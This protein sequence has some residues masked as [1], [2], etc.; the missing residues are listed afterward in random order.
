MSNKDIETTTNE[1]IE[2]SETPK[3]KNIVHVFRPQNTQNGGN[4]GRRTGGNRQGQGA[5]G[6]TMQVNNGRP[7][8]RQAADDTAK[9]TES[10]DQAPKRNTERTSDR[11]QTSRRPERNDRNDRNDGRGDNR[12]NNRSG[13]R[14]QGGRDGRSDRQEGRGGQRF[15]RGDR[16]QNGRSDRNQGD[17]DNRRDNNR[18]G[19]DRQG[20]KFSD[21]NDNRTWRIS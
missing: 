11:P 4:K 10:A 21:R 3:K 6:K 16:P 7:S 20:R 1:N 17:R 18:G 19:D 8:R 15:Q 9:R 12:N 2:K 14:R 13:E 5:Q